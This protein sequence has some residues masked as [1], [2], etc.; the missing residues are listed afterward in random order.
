MAA[1]AATSFGSEPG[2]AQHGR[3]GNCCRSREQ[4]H[5]VWPMQQNLRKFLLE[6][7][8][9]PGAINPSSKATAKASDWI[10]WTTS[11]LP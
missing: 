1:H 10:D 4:G 5:F 6:T 2:R 8:N 11:A 3:A 7:G 9:D